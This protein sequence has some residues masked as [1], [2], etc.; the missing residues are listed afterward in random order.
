MARF[1]GSMKGAR[2]EAT[3]CGT[4]TSGIH[5]HIR[6]WHVGARVEVSNANGIDVVRVYRTGGSSPKQG[7][8]LIAEYTSN[9][10]A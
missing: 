6:G 7:D 4:A 1:Y 8:E 10:T 2:G 5:A 3:R 9:Y